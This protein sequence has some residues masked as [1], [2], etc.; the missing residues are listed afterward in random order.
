M[1]KENPFSSRIHLP[2]AAL[3]AALLVAGL[4]PAAAAVT[5]DFEKLP[6][7]QVLNGN[8]GWLSEASVGELITRM[9]GTPENGT[10]VAQPLAGVASGFFAFLTRVNDLDFR[11]SPF[12]GMESSAVIEFE[13]SAAAVAG[14]ALGHDI[15]GD[16]M[17][18]LDLGEW[19]PA[20]GTFHEPEQGVPNFIIHTS[21]TSY[22]APLTSAERCCNFDTDWYRLRLRM[23]LTANGGAGACSLQPAACSL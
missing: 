5:Y 16:G 11:F 14:V 21:V 23:D 10:Q 17:L 22:L 19:G 7:N 13:A 12:F 18:S 1:Q 3:T 9:D 8:D 2:M 20:F 15:N 4:V 6:L